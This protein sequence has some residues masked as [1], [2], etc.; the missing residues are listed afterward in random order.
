MSLA[1]DPSKGKAA[2]RRSRPA[3]AGKT[4]LRT[5]FD[6]KDV[7]LVPLACECLLLITALLL[8]LAFAQTMAGLPQNGYW[9]LVALGGAVFLI[10]KNY[11]DFR[12]L[13]MPRVIAFLGVGSLM[14]G[15]LALIVV[16]LVLR[17]G[18]AEKLE[19][20]RLLTV[21]LPLVLY[22][23]REYLL[24][25]TTRFAP[26]ISTL[27]RRKNARTETLVARTSRVIRFWLD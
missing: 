3:P 23:G 22:I 4:M 9:T 8:A 19:G 27:G 13:F 15:A 25:R 1:H 12:E 6:S 24:L 26:K 17:P 11:A 16:L 7:W 21:P 20:L 5:L 2:K 18:A 10:A 14:V